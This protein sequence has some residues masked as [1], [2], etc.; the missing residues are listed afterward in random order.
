[1]RAESLFPEISKFQGKKGSFFGF[2]GE[3]SSFIIFPDRPER[4]GWGAW[5]AVR[6][7]ED[8][9]KRKVMAILLSMGLIAGLLTGCAS[10]ADTGDAAAQNASGAA[11]TSGAGTASAEQPASEETAGSDAVPSGTGENVAAAGEEAQLPDDGT[12][13]AYELGR[14]LGNGINLGNT[15]EA[16]GHKDGTD[17]PVSYYE[18]LWGQP[19]TT[20]EMISFYKS[21]GFDT[22]RIPVAWT[23]MMDFESGDYTIAED[24]LARVKEIVDYAYAADMYVIVNDHWDGGWWGLFG[25]ADEHKRAAAMEQYISMWTQIAE[26]FRDYDDHLIFEGANEEIGDRLND[27]DADF[28]PDGAVLSK[29]ECYAKANEINQTFVDVVR[30]TGGNNATRYLLIPGYG[31]DITQ[32]LDSRWHMPTDSAKDRLFLS[33][34]Y[35]TPWSYCGSGGESTWGTQKDYQEMNRLLE[36]LSTYTEQG[37]G[38]ILGECGVLPTSSVTAK[39]N[40]VLW[41]EN[42]FANCDLYNYVPVLWDTGGAIDKRTLTWYDEEVRECF[43]E[44][45]LASDAGK[46]QEEIE[47]EAKKTM[48]DALAAAPETFRTDA[49]LSG[50]GIAVAWIMWDSQDWNTVYSVGDTYNPDSVT[51][52]VVATD[53][54]ITG[55]G[56]YTVALDFTGTDLGYCTST[57]FSAIGISN[58]E[59][60]FPGYIINIKSLLINGEEYK[61]KG[62]NYTASDDGLCTRSNLYNGWVNKLPDD[63]R[64]PGG[65][66]VG[67]TPCVLDPQDLGDIETLEITFTYLPGE[68]GIS[69]FDA[70]SKN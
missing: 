63:A 12:L 3:A 14:I 58:G 26:Y 4:P 25:S 59:V 20:Q 2:F 66:L 53:V 15:M 42:F 64:A 56:T 30:G 18:T 48:E 29:E 7:E 52:G 41:Y 57:A 62:R 45:S 65:T 16:Y 32:T 13:S 23:N 69:T 1:L 17:R 47:A 51:A 68:E 21:E 34:H 37:Y 31:T 43:H 28:N 19:V 60:M 54:Q 24:Y 6:I 67:C 27:I 38:V 39:P 36:E 10:G 22:L 40:S 55:E 9:V 11:D 33:V 5:N 50:D 35:Y 49:L 44:A 61:L 70:N 8:S 46:T